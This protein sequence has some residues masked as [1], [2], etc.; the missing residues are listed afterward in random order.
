MLTTDLAA[1]VLY[2]DSDLLV[3]DKPAGLPVHGGP[4]AKAS[5]EDLLDALRFGLREAPRPAHRLDQDTSGCLVLGRHEKA[6]KKLGRL[7]SGR[8]VGKTYWAILAGEPPEESGVIDR[9]LRKHNERSGWRMVIDPAGQSA[10]TEF[11]RR[12]RGDG[13]SWVEFRPLTGRTHQIR[14]HAAH[15]GC[16][17]LGDPVYAGKAPMQPMM[18]H[19]RRLILPYRANKPAIDVTA[20]PPSHMAPLLRACGWDGR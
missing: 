14:V 8:D 12:G 7:F 20:S 19:A 16:P 2:R 11:Q 4:K 13:I 17:V 5:I 9:A 1:R 18:L 10:Q 3:I 6:M 15:L